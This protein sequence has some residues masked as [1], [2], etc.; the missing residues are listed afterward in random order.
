MK[1]FWRTDRPHPSE[2]KLND[3]E[4]RKAAVKEL[5]R[6]IEAGEIRV[7]TTP[8]QTNW[9]VWVEEPGRRQTLLEWAEEFAGRLP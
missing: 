6:L 1:V 9:N 3:P 4:V 7:Y 5:N 2:F 8:D